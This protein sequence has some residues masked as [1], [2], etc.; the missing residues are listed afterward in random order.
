VSAAAETPV[1]EIDDLRP[2]QHVTGSMVLDPAAS[3][4]EW[5]VDGRIHQHRAVPRSGSPLVMNDPRLSGRLESTW[6]WD[7]H[8]SG[9]QPVPAWGTMRIDVPAVATVRLRGADQATVEVGLE[10]GAWVGDFT[11]IRRT[12]GEPFGVRALLIG[13]GAYEGLCATLDFEA[14]D[15]AWLADGLIHMVPMA[16]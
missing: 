16:G 15:R 4:G 1:Y 11:G 14:G 10:D 7:I 9:S 3:L 5:D 6:N 13:E 8:S 12:D 2:M